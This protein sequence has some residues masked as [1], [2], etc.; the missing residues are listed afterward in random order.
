MSSNKR[1]RKKLESIY[2]KGCM[3]EKADVERRIEERRR[4]YNF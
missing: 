2:G 3:F 1:I 4:Y